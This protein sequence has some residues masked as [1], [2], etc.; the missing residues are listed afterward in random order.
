LADSEQARAEA[1]DQSRRFAR[2]GDFK[3][4]WPI[5]HAQSKNLKDLTHQYADS[6]GVL[7][8][9]FCYE[10]RL[11]DFK[12]KYTLFALTVGTDTWV[13]S[14]NDPF[15]TPE[16]ELAFPELPLKLIWYSPDEI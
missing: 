4:L 9:V 12:G 16:I 10:Y 8:D 6:E 5:F 7:E 15:P 13:I 3:G 14:L 2:D 1:Y 11:L